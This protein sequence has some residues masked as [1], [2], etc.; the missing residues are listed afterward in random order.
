MV[1]GGGR[2]R[3]RR[4]KRWKALLLILAYFGCY[5]MLITITG[6]LLHSGPTEQAGNT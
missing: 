3:G 6:I 5:A 1:E 4:W 2:E